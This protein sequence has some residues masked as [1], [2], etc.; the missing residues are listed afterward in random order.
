MSTCTVRPVLFGPP[1]K[2]GDICLGGPRRRYPR[3]PS[4]FWVL[5]V[6]L[7]TILEVLVRPSPNKYLI[8]RPIKTGRTVDH[9][10]QHAARILVCY[11]LTG[12]DA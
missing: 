5:F 9:G 10:Q 6:V 8:S 2:N 7:A 11:T 4:F 3:F 1:L 12:T